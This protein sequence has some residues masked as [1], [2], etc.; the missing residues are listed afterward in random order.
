MAMVGMASTLQ[1]KFFLT[2]ATFKKALTERFDQESC[3]LG[4]LTKFRQTSTVDEDITA[5]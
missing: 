5:F 1:W 2:W 4:R 3:F